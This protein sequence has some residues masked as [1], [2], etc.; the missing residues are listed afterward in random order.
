MSDERSKAETDSFNV[1]VGAWVETYMRVLVLLERASRNEATG[2]EAKNDI[3][4]KAKDHML[5][6]ADMFEQLGVDAG[7]KF[8]GR[9]GWSSAEEL[10]QFLWEG[11]TPAN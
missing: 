5:K 3:A 7:D 9:L 4:R 8:A 2:P 10:S 11:A 1:E 6:V